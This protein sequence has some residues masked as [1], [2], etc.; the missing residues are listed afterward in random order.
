[1]ADRNRAAYEV[2]MEAWRRAHAARTN[3]FA[4]LVEARYTH[5]FSPFETQAL[6]DQLAISKLLV[7]VALT[8]LEC[9]V[10]QT[11]RRES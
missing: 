4:R 5:P 3:A 9:A 7:E 2:A 8:Q 6:A 1:V 10:K 11:D